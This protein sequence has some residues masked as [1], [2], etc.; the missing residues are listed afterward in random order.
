M[1]AL[2]LLDTVV[3]LIDIP[4]EEIRVGDI[5]TISDVYTQMSLSY[6]V[7]FVTADGTPRAMVT[8]APDQIRTLSNRDVLTVRQLPAA[9]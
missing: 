6:E 1:E 8:L 9:G 3:I 5:G 2:Q 4:E 7:E